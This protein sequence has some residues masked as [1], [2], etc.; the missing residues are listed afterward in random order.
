MVLL[1]MK[2][3]S[4]YDLSSVLTYLFMKNGFELGM[5]A[6]ASLC[7]W[8]DGAIRYNTDMLPWVLS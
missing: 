2:G 7:G 6:C 3:P 4:Y 1:L 5:L 8:L